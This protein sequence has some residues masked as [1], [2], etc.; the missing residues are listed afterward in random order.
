[1]QRF[2]TASRRVFDRSMVRIISTAAFCRT[3]HGL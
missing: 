3:P 1:M 2:R